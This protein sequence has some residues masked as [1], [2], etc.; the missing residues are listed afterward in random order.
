MPIEEKYEEFTLL[1][2]L[3]QDS[4]YAFQ[5]LFDRY[6]NRIYRVAISYVKS[7]ILAEEIVQ[8]VF[9]KVWFQRKEIRK[10]RSFEAWL[11][12]VSKNY[13]L[14]YLKKLAGE[15]KAREN[16]VM[17]LDLSENTT[18]ALI[19]TSQFRQLLHDAVCQLPE[20]QQRVYRLAKEEFLSYEEIAFQLKISP[21]T[22]K[23]HMARALEAIRIFLGH[24]GALF[25]LLLLLKF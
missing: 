1:A 5:L 6:R 7:P 11:F 20:Q 16:W 23:T 3:A 2:M 19:R 14:N 21:L 8:D 15:W 17:Q 25:A 22:V 24:Q 4:E 18:D 9:L 10:L 12:T 13:V